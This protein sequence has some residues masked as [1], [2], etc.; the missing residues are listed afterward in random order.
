MGRPGDLRANSASGLPGSLETAGWGGGIGEEVKPL[1]NPLNQVEPSRGQEA[2]PPW[3][4]G[5][6]GPR[7]SHGMQLATGLYGAIYP[8]LRPVNP[9]SFPCSLPFRG[10]G[11]GRQIQNPAGLFPIQPP[12]PRG[13]CWASQQDWGTALRGLLFS[14]LSTHSSLIHWLLTHV[15]EQGHRA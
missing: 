14:F 13:V 6:P 3:L 1:G 2:A 5:R 9:G 7:L 15:T 4:P 12:A 11:A 10:L 8:R